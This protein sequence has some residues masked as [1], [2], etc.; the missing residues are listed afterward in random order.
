M[1]KGDII[2]YHYGHSLRDSLRKRLTELM[3]GRR[4]TA[5]NMPQITE[6]SKCEQG[7]CG[8]YRKC[9]WPFIHRGYIFPCL[10]NR[11]CKWDT[12]YLYDWILSIHIQCKFA[13]K[14]NF[15]LNCFHILIITICW[16]GIYSFQTISV[17]I[18]VPFSPL[19]PPPPSNCQQR[20]K[21][22]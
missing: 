21:D 16:V 9:S 17:E 12:R 8:S 1:E 13:P 20:K 11:G 14:F 18:G 10:L 19:I 3:K 15:P 7:E 4:Y 22:A 5:E 2:W 6:F